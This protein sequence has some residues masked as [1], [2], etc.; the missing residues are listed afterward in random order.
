MHGTNEQSEPVGFPSLR[1]ASTQKGAHLVP[2]A[3]LGEVSDACFDA[4]EVTFRIQLVG[5]VNDPLCR[6][7]WPASDHRRG[8]VV[9]TYTGHT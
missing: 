4:R 5:N 7:L 6:A 2:V 1:L 8:R 3:L 9:P